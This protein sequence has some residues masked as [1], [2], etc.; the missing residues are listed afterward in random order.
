[1][2]ARDSAAAK[3]AAKKA[4]YGLAASAAILATLGATHHA[5][6]DHTTTAAAVISPASAS[7]PAAARGGHLTT[8]F[9]HPFYDQTQA[10][11]VEAKDLHP[12]DTLQ[13]PTGTNQITAV[14]LHHAN[15]TTYDLTIGD[16]HTHYVLAGTTPILVHNCSG[17]T[18]PNG[19]ACSCNGST[20]PSNADLVQAIATRAQARLGGSGAVSGNA[21]HAYADTL[22]TRYQGIYGNRGLITEQS[23]LRGL[24]V[25]RGTAGSA[26]PDV[27]DPAGG[28]V[29]DYKFVKNPGLG[30]GKWQADKNALNVPGVNLTVEVNP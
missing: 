17:G 1:M 13:T 2:K 24:P 10:A 21:K 20:N 9:H 19:A 28:I 22:L 29:Y 23:Y 6:T 5:T 15:T 25:P 4:A 30:I 27:F 26:R 14:R 8:T 16:L 7:A 12:G 3:S 18:A 11:F